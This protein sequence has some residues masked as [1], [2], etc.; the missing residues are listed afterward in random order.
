MSCSGRCTI[1]KYEF[2]WEYT[3]DPIAAGS[4]CPNKKTIKE[5]AD[6]HAEYWLDTKYPETASKCKPSKKK[7]KESKA[8]CEC[9][10]LEDQDP[11]PTV[12][13]S[14]L[15]KSNHFQ[16]ERSLCRIGYSIKYRF[17]SR[18]YDGNCQISTG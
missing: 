13:S 4:R 10:E 12:W 14:W 2:E 7:K 9:V 1:T 6:W 16:F 15:S 5:E 17:R 8:L 3:V 11:K 18:L